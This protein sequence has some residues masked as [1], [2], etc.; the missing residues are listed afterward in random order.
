GGAAGGFVGVGVGVYVLK[1]TKDTRSII[2]STSSVTANATTSDGLS[3]I[4]DGTVTSSGFG[5]A[6]FRGAAV[7]AQSSEDIF[8]I[9]VSLGAGFVGV[10][11]PVGVT[12]IDVTTQATLAGTISSGRDV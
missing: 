1:L 10:A 12:L 2:A 6:T 7:Q 5:F 11:I 8:G 4:S 3:G 9:V